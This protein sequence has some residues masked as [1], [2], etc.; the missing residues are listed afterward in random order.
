MYNGFQGDFINMIRIAQLT[1]D[2]NH[3]RQDLFYDTGSCSFYRPEAFYE[4]YFVF[5][6]LFLA[7]AF[8]I[9]FAKPSG[10]RKAR[11]S[12]RDTFGI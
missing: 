6:M 1:S 8:L 12:I 5:N 10:C 3:T 9:L 2:E 7:E 4:P 11:A